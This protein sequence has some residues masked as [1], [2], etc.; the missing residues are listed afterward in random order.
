MAPTCAVQVLKIQI[1]PPPNLWSAAPL[2]QVTSLI[3]WAGLSE[4][5]RRISARRSFRSCSNR[6]K[7][8]GTWRVGSNSGLYIARGAEDSFLIKS[9]EV[10]AWCIHLGTLGVYIMFEAA[11]VFRHILEQSGTSVEDPGEFVIASPWILSLLR[12]D[13]TQACHLAWT[14]SQ[15]SQLMGIFVSSLLL[16]CFPKLLKHAD[17][18]EKEAEVW[19]GLLRSRS[20]GSICLA[21]FASSSRVLPNPVRRLNYQ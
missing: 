12:H 20:R 16:C 15:Q 3:E 21:S 2:S 8:A 10:A 6:H 19:T 1:C 7:D 9:E 17:L 14:D 11:F 5:E 18:I 4:E 13:L